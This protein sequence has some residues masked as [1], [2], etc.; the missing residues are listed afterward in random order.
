MCICICLYS[1][2]TLVIVK[3]PHLPRRPF[4][5]FGPPAAII[6]TSSHNICLPLIFLYFLTL[7]RVSTRLYHIYCP[8]ISA[9]HRPHHPIISPAIEQVSLRRCRTMLYTVARLCKPPS[10]P[11]R[12]SSVDVPAIP[13]LHCHHFFPPVSPFPSSLLYHISDVACFYR[14]FFCFPCLLSLLSRVSATAVFILLR[15][16]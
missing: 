12:I 2:E 7:H 5:L 3:P 13:R 10:P 15:L 1:S 6:Y 9:A 4:L 14:H 11:S 16:Y 8:I